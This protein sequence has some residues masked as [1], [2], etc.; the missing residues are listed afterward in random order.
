MEKMFFKLRQWILQKNLST[1]KQKFKKIWIKFKYWPWCWVFNKKIRI[2][3][4]TSFIKFD[5]HFHWLVIRFIIFVGDFFLLHLGSLFHNLFALSLQYSKVVLAVDD[6]L[7]QTDSCAFGR[8]GRGL[9]AYIHSA[10]VWTLKWSDG[11]M[12]HTWSHITWNK[13]FLWLNSS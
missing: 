12:F 8:L 13:S 6:F 1:I 5:Y 11:A 9:L 2:V 4:Q 7:L 10:D 3:Q